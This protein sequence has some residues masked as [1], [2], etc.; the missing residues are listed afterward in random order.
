MIWIALED[1]DKQIKANILSEV[2]AGNDANILDSTEL[3]TIAEV[4]SYLRA[5]Y[6]VNV[7]FSAT[8]NDRN[9]LLLLIVIDIFLYHVHSRL[10]PNQIPEIRV[11]R[12]DEAKRML[13]D[14][15]KGIVDPGL[16]LLTAPDGETRSK[17][18]HGSDGR[19]E[20]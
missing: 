17:L 20:Y 4:Q 1:L 19:R 16:P 3:A 2:T 15:A 10:N 12:Y 5:K 14:I 6:D 11:K 8:G 18:L 9:A 7:I 13:E